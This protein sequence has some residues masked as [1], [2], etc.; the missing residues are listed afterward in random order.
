MHETFYDDVK[1]NS[2]L[3]N[4]SRDLQ[5]VCDKLKMWRGADWQMRIAL[6]LFPE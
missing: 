3:D 5:T 2:S 1:L 4:L 6:V